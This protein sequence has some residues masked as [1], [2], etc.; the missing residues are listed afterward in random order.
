MAKAKILLVESESEAIHLISSIVTQMGYEV[1]KTV[2]NSREALKSATQLLPDIIMIGLHLKGESNGIETAG[3]INQ[4]LNI[5][6][7]YLIRP[8]DKPLLERIKQT[9]HDGYLFLPP[10]EAELHFSIELAMARHKMVE[11]I[12]E[13]QA[14]LS[15]T[16]KS[17]GDAVIT[18]DPQ[19]L[20]TFLNPVAEKLTGW[21]V[22]EAA[23]KNLPEVFNIIN[24]HT[25][26]KARNPVKRILDKGVV[27][28]LANH[29]MLISK[30]G[31]YIPI[32]DSGA[33]IRDSNGKILGAVLVF[34]DITERRQ[35]E[36]AL[37]RERHLL[38]TVIDNIPDK[39][40]AKDLDGR[41]IVC[42]NAV[43][44]RMGK[45]DPQEVVGKSDFDLLPR[46]LAAQFYA[47]EQEII[48]SGQP[49]INHEEPLDQVSGGVR[50]NSAT[51]VPLRD[52]HGKTIGI[53]GIGRDIT[54]RKQ[55]EEALAKE[56]NLLRTLI[57]NLPDYI[58][59]KDRNGRFILGNQAVIHQMGFSTLEELTGKSDYDLFPKDVAE[60]YLQDEQKIIQSGQGLFE[61]EGP[62]IDTSKPEK[63]RWVLTSKVPFRDDNGQIL[64]FVGLGHDITERRRAEEALRKEMAFM[65][66]LMQN[67]PDHIYFKDR[68]SRFLRMSKSQAE[69]FG[70]ADPQEAIGKTDFNFFTEEH[71]R[72][73]FQDE[74]KIIQSG[75]PV[76]G[77]EEK[78]TWP[79]GSET[80][81]ST[82]KMPLMDNNGNIVGTFGISRDITDRKKAE[83]N[84][85]KALADLQDSQGKLK[86][87]IN[88]S[89]IPQFF[90]DK[91]HT[92]MYW[93][94]ALVKLTGL[95]SQ[96]MI[97]SQNHSKAFYN[98]PRPCLADLI[99]DGTLDR[100][101][102]LYPDKFQKSELVEDGY[103]ATDFFPDLGQTG[104]WMFFTAVAIRDSN[105]NIIGA[106][107][108]LEDITDRKQA[109]QQREKV[110]HDLQEALKKIN[111]LRGLI[112]I[113]ANCKKIRDDKGYWNNVES[114]IH[115]HADVEFTHGICPD[116][117][118]KLYPDYYKKKELSESENS[119]E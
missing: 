54:K 111:T 42:N 96:D 56:H 3:Q 80:W 16:L 70:L 29:T 72:S 88:G 33:P 15:T 97:G 78:E 37:E 35:A 27:T 85:K 8:D 24:E 65:N 62:T 55:A 23:G 118:K 103:Q 98:Q 28:A 110:I 108:T 82:T 47:N 12:K 101:A 87:V 99:V 117:M 119:P 48:R 34:R 71:A 41:F 63:N 59:V 14:L 32:D 57:D 92:V 49:Q 7:I 79:D 116:C 64:G 68:D 107:E 84:L 95:K 51:K 43:I 19:G 26:L 89:S 77:I 86:K 105:N 31:R 20:I 22:N 60:K 104:R 5:P 67:L 102:E 81:V 10:S 52:K 93:N 30:D 74:Q 109:E 13:K 83:E 115:S 69:R 40:Y 113:C 36:E 94:D 90:I 44:D 17:I 112:P 2:N 6:I 50:W 9:R 38:R 58:Y 76:I 53:V 18:T 11:M 114:Y 39:I 100:I 91:N 106:L 46:D 73:A 21:L 25:G 66:T 75:R 61:H 4:K 45:S 1:L